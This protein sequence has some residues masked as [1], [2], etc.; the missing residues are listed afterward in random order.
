MLRAIASE[1]CELAEQ[2][3]GRRACH[4]PSRQF[5]RQRA[6][7]AERDGGMNMSLFSAGLE[8]SHSLRLQILLCIVV[9]CHK[10]RLADVFE[11]SFRFDVNVRAVLLPS[12]STASSRSRA[13]FNFKVTHSPSP[14]ACPRPLHAHTPQIR[15]PFQLTIAIAALHST[16]RPVT[17]ARP[18]WQAPSGDRAASD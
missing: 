6:C 10:L 17:A 7:R 16:E 3:T 12:R 2:T 8:R 14:R 13:S 5:G 9:C 18:R 1:R 4:P 15:T 11:C